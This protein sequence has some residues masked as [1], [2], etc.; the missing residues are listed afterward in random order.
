MVMPGNRE[1]QSSTGNPVREEM[2]A[3]LER[4][5]AILGK[6]APVKPPVANVTPP[7]PPS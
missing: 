4:L 5:N 1:S 2:V 3:E 6:N 7:Y